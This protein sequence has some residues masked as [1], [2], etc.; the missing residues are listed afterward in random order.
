VNYLGYC[1]RSSNSAF[2]L[3]FPTFRRLV[4]R[5]GTHSPRDAFSW[6]VERE[7]MTIKDF[8]RMM[9]AICH[10]SVREEAWHGGRER[11]DSEEKECFL[12]C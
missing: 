8:T 1:L 3:G 4:H 6:Q 12:G 2:S 7:T 9:F 5:N 11:G 10:Q